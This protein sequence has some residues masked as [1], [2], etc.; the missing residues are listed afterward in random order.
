MNDVKIG[1]YLSLILRHKPQIIGIELD[2]NGWADTEELINGVKN[3]FP[4]FNMEQLEHIVKTNDKKRYSFNEDKSKIR[5]NQGHSLNVDVELKEV[6]PPEFLYHGTARRFLFS[7]MKNGLVPGSRIYVHLSH[8]EET[9]ER[10]GRRH[11]EPVVLKIEAGKMNKDGFSFY[12]SENGVWLTKLVPAEY[13]TI[14]DS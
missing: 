11:G 9:A 8:D 3:K 5:A 7:I 4:Y 2:K 12:L 14:L 1:K 10:V 13:F 6:Q